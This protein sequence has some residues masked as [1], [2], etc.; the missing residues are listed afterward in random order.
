MS[1]PSLR[2]P[3]LRTPRRG[4]ESPSEAALLAQIYNAMGVEVEMER[5]QTKVLRLCPS[6]M[7][8]FRPSWAEASSASVMGVEEEQGQSEITSVVSGSH[9]GSSTPTSSMLFSVEEVE[10]KVWSQETEAATATVEDEDADLMQELYGA[11]EEQLRQSEASRPQW[12]NAD[13]M[14]R[15]L[16]IF[17]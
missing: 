10:E 13:A 4:A 16:C 12:V 11:M 17:F 2:T 1:S 15:S 14:R 5:A 8:D 6:K 7:E 9:C 3:S